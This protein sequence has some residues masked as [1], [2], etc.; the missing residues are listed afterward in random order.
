MEGIFCWVISVSLILLIHSSNSVEEAVKQSLLNFFQQLNDGK[1]PTDPNFGWNSTSDPCLS[2]WSGIT[3]SRQLSVKK[4]VLEGLGFTGVLDANSICAVPSLIVLSV[5]NNRIHGE[6]P[7]EIVRCKQFTHL[8]INDNQFSGNLPASLSRLNNLK[9]L[10]IENNNFTGELPDLPKISGLI[11]FLAQYNQFSGEIPKFDFTNLVEF[12]VSFNNFSGPIPDLSG[13]FGE[14][15]FLGNSRL[16]GKPLLNACPPSSEPKSGAPPPKSRSKQLERILMYV[17]YILIA[18]IIILFFVYK[19]ISRKKKVKRS[20][21]VEQKRVNEGKATTSSDSSG[22]KNGPSRSDY[23]IPSSNES[24][25]TS[26]SLVVLENPVVKELRFEDLLKAPA[27]LMGRGRHGTL[28]KVM[29]EDTVPLAVK[30]IRDW[31]ISSEDFRKRM[32]NIDRVDHPNVSP[33]L[34]FYS[35]RQEKLV[36]YEYQQNGSLFKLLHGRN[37]NIAKDLIGA[38]DLVLQLALLEAWLHAHRAS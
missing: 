34:A 4:V 16:C 20:T 25:M 37:Q 24:G 17:G 9:R 28:Y 14:D 6:I 7:T 19:I 33:V 13:R 3:C 26:A 21:D 2:Q 36:V 31:S 8:Y 18:L 23:S 1:R 35:S 38:I 22:Y 29:L 27:E 32:E 10:F 12:N 5:Q 30:R 11:S 15:S